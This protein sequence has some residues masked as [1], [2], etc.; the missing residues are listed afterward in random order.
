MPP[1]TGI[2]LIVRDIF[3]TAVSIFNL[4]SKD[5]LALCPLKNRTNL[6]YIFS[7]GSIFLMGNPSKPAWTDDDKIISLMEQLINRSGNSILKLFRNIIFCC[8]HNRI[9]LGYVKMKQCFPLT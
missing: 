8:P 1:V 7:K 9:L 5:T 2:D 4:R 3:C 6:I